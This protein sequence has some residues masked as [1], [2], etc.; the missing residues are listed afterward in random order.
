MISKTLVPMP[1]CIEKISF[2]TESSASTYEDRQLTAEDHRGSLQSLVLD[3]PIQ[4]VGEVNLEGSP[5]KTIRVIE[6]H[7]GGSFDKQRAL[8]VTQD[9]EVIEKTE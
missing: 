3:G 1:M 8:R 7:R 9:W 2:D 5:S 6:K 4:N